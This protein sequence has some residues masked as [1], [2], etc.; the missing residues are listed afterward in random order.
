MNNKTESTMSSRKDE[1]PGSIR[2]KNQ[3]I[4]P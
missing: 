2:E 4:E 1:I 3:D